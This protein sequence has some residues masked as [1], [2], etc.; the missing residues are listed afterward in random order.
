GL[1]RS[2]HVRTG[3]TRR[4]L[5]PLRKKS[6]EVSSQVRYIKGRIEGNESSRALIRRSTWFLPILSGQENGWQED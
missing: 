2:Q 6:V 3:P 4:G 1:A 5:G